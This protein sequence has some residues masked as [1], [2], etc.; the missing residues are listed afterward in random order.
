MNRRAPLDLALGRATMMEDHRRPP[1]RAYRK[2][3]LLAPTHRHELFSMPNG[4]NFNMVDLAE[5]GQ[6]NVFCHWEDVQP[7]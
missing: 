2:Q 7:K 3:H 5:R 1:R 6:K 4:S